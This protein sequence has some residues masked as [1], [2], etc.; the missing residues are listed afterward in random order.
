M[1]SNIT[2]DGRAS[3]QTILLGQPQFRPTLAGPDVEQLRQRVLASYHLGPMSEAETR[4]Y[5]E[6]RMKTVGWTGLNP[7]WEETAFVAV[8]NRT[9]GIPRRINT[10]CSRVMLYG[11]LEEANTITAI[12]VDETANEQIQ[13]LGATTQVPARPTQLPHTA[14]HADIGQTGAGVT[15][16]V[17]V[18]EQGLARQERAFRRL[19]DMV[20][21]LVEHPR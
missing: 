9:L 2:V 16:R 7:Y 8:F 14:Q 11:S 10:L 18:L 21:T 12:M 1:L 6:H 19:M 20:S 3:V 13:D 4:A 17:E 15:R 5:V